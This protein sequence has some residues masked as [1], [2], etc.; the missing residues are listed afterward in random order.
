MKNSSENNYVVY[1]HTR[2]DKNI[3][4]Y[5]GIGKPNRPYDFHQRSE[6]WFRVFNKTEIEVTILHSNLTREKACEYEKAYI[7]QY[8]TIY[9]KNG[10]LVNLTQGGDGF[11]GNHTE[12]TRNKISD[13]LKEKYQTGETKSFWKGKT[14]PK[15]MVEKRAKWLRDNYHPTEEHRKIL[16]EKLTGSGNGMFGKDPWNKGIPHTEEQKKKLRE[17]HKGMTGRKHSPETIERM[18]IAAQNR[19][20]NNK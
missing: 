13:T 3:P 4:F 15:E 7:S 5:V 18:R 6:L 14:Q 16:S 12:D 1:L 8:G 17:N 10:S 9:G 19:K 2:L 20:N 11:S